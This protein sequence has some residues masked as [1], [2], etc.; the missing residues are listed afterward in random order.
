MCKGGGA[1]LLKYQNAPPLSL[2]F[3]SLDLIKKS[4]RAIKTLLQKSNLSPFF[5]VEDARWHQKPTD[6]VFLT[7]SNF[8][9]YTTSHFFNPLTALSINYP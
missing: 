1:L 5:F 3:S 2:F 4:H 7:I 9:L 6:L 8:L